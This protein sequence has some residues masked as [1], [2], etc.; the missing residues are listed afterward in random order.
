MA[1]K[2]IFVSHVIESLGSGGAERLLYTNLKYLGGERFRHTVVTVFSHQ[3]FWAKQIQDLGVEVH[4]LNCRGGSDIGNATARLLSWLRRHKPDLIHSHLW[5]ADLVARVAGRLAGVPVISSIHSSLHEA[6]AWGDGSDV[7]RWKRVAVRKLDQWT[8][9][10]GS[11]R[12]IAVSEYVRQSASARLKYPLDQIALLYNP[13]DLDDLDSV[14]RYTGA[15]LRAELGLAPDAFLL[16]NVGRI[17]PQKGLL[18]AIRALPSIIQRHPNT[19]LVSVGAKTNGEW[20]ATLQAEIAH[21]GMQNHVHLLGARTDVAALLRQCDIFL[22]P[23]IFEGLPLA[24]LEAMAAACV[25]IASD[26]GALPEVIEHDIT[27]LLIPPHS[28]QDISRA[29][30][31]LLE[32]PGKR[33]SLGQAAEERVRARFSPQEAAAK[34]ANIYESVLYA[35][36]GTE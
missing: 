36:S 4:S 7:S 11:N 17:S 16:L 25:C 18:Y 20:L 21:Q 5:T 26:V 13:V 24:L 19:H 22:F 10:F 9:R 30:G 8:A 33:A 15:G 35:T 1:V 28:P 3:T 14:P 2:P 29:V 32:N 31:E 12:M 34:L 23:S 6:E 27:G